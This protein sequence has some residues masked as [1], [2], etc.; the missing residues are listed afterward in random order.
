MLRSFYRR[1]LPVWLLLAATVSAARA[2][3]VLDW[4]RV[5]G[6][7]LVNNQSLQNPGMASRSM[8]MMNLAIYDAVAM[9][10]PG[11]TMF[12]NYGGGHT[13]PGM[14]ADYKA[15]AA[16]A[17]YTV[18]SG[19]Y[20][21]Q[22]ARLDAA[23]ATSLS[24]IAD[25]AAKSEGLAVG[26]MIGQS[27]LSRR[28]G[29]GYNSMSQYLPTAAPGH[30][31]PDPLNPGQQAW[32]PAWGEVTPFALRSNRQ[33]MPGSMPSL[34]SQAY[35]DA[36]NEVKELGA[37]NSTTR[38]A[39]QTEIGYFWAYDRSGMGTPHRLFSDVLD[40]IAVQQG[41][42]TKENAELFAKATVAMADAGVV[43]WNS[44]FEYDFWR[45]VTGIR[46]ADT[47]GNSLTEA[48]P[49]WT[50]L[51]APGGDHSDFTP[52]FPTYVSGH[53]T[54]GGALFG[55]LQEFY[56]TDDIAFELESQEMPGIVRN[57]NSFSEAMAENGR[58]RVYLG[59]HWNFDDTVGQEVGQKIA[60]F[61]FQRPFVAVPEPAALAAALTGV[62]GLLF[63][64][65][66]G[67]RA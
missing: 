28:A 52:P 41:N 19:I 59:I 64:R 60:R 10:S 2:D 61:L 9:T 31:Q 43:A 58:S 37:A 65:R 63:R 67:E 25:G 57:F 44:K 50:P 49:N 13:S 66:R 12:F 6:D 36:F 40:T 54:F 14:T 21:D 51:G 3:V 23:L 20:D 4:N 5:A 48:D 11:E 17:A 32:G 33:F 47:D 55:V 62:A 53:A 15:A 35:A 30:W 46:E 7:V 22:S 16:Q 39:E 24:A 34:T 29:D 27:I 26:T 45:P 56:G 18:L 42:T 8:A 1:V 38:T